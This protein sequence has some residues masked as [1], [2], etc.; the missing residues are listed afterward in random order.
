MPHPTSSTYINVTSIMFTQTSLPFLCRYHT[1]IRICHTHHVLT[2]VTTIPVQISHPHTYMPHPSCSHRRH[3]HSCAD[4]TP[5][6]VY[7]TPIMFSQ[8]SLPFLCRYH[9]H[10]RICHIHHVHT[11]VTTIPVQITHPHTYMPHPSCSHRRHYHSCADITPTY[12]YATS[13][14]F[15]QT[16][17]PFLCRYHTHI[18]ICHIHHVHTD[19]TTIP[20]QISH[21]H[22]YMPH[23]SC[24][25]RRHYHSCADITPTY[26][27]ATSIMFTQT[28]PP[29]LCRYHTHIRICHIHHVH[30]D[31]TTIPVQISHPHTYMPHPSCSHRR[32][33]HSCADIT[34]TYVYATPTS[35]C[36]SN[37]CFSSIRA[38]TET[39]SLSNLA[40]TQVL[41]VSAK[42][43]QG[44][45]NHNTGDT[46]CS[47]ITAGLYV[48]AR[49]MLQ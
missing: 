42:S 7:A 27:Y 18:R 46:C 17:L 5:T 49:L 20:V 34:P 16:S 28:S 31:V 10:I 36:C 37:S 29:F 12:V 2:D 4:I 48:P 15:T 3:Y 11:D 1:H 41:H 38:S 26:V 22:T 43:Q 8:T 30:T 33:Y 14:M 44:V 45:H 23:P 6:Y 24:S 9:T 32:H 21:P 25:H 13:I 40:T 47:K 19:V 35:F 39:S